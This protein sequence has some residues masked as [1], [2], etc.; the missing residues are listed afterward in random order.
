MKKIIL[1]FVVLAFAMACSQDP[2]ERTSKKEETFSFVFL[3]DIHLQPQRNANVGFLQAIDTINK[4][5][6]D[7]VL[8]G[9]DNIYDALG[10]TYERS[11]SLYDLYIESMKNFTMPVYNTIGN[12]DVFGL[13]EKSG[14]EPTHVWQK[15]V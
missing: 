2:A 13:Y 14:V 6:P 1:L 3:A 4:M 10:Q 7:F 9:G 12:H 15:D 11:K 5:A 8:T